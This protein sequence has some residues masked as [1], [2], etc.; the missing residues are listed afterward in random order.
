MD[1]RSEPVG[2]EMK[3]G[4][5]GIGAD[6]EKKRKFKEEVERKAGAEKRLKVEEGDFRQRNRLEREQKRKEGQVIGAQKVCE[7]LEEEEQLAGS[8][9]IKTQGEVGDRKAAPGIRHQH[10]LLPGWSD[11]QNVQIARRSVSQVR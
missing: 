2:L 1:G 10:H 4:R 11:Q 7:R 6:S 8:S 3:E 5:S 9:I